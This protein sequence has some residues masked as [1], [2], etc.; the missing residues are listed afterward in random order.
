MRVATFVS[1]NVRLPSA[2]YSLA[3]VGH[4]NVAGNVFSVLLEMLLLCLTR[5]SASVTSS[6][7]TSVSRQVISFSAIAVRLP[8]VIVAVFV[9]AF[10]FA[11]LAV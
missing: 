7:P 1:V 4:V 2:S 10:R 11:G 3:S 6:S 9:V 8:K 5:G